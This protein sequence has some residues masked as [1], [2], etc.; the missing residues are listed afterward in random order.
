M[1][2]LAAIFFRASNA[3]VWH[4]DTWAHWKFGQWI[5]EHGR[6]PER[7]PFSPYGDHS[8]PLVDTLWLSQVTCYLVYARLGMEGIAL[9][10]ALVELMRAALYLE[11]LRR[12]WGSLWLAILGLALFQAGRWIYFGVFR[13]Q[14]FG[15]VCWTALLLACA[16]PTLSRATLVWMPAVMLLWANLHGSFLLGLALLGVVVI[17]R[18]VEQARRSRGLAAAAADRNLRLWLWLF[19]LCLA[20]TCV[21]PF[22]P[23]LLVEVARFGNQPILQYV[24]EWLPLAP[25]ATYESRVLVASFVAVLITLRLSPRRLD[26]A[27][28]VLLLLF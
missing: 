21:N 25:L 8:H 1:V 9:A 26:P 28:A 12:V 7:D 22:G 18:L 17:G 5:C 14:S 24:K 3:P 6:L 20:A 16:R 11:A 15:E 2:L 10:Y 19:G 27:D 4:L 13:P 23:R